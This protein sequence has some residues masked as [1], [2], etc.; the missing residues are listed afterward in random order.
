ML[1]TNVPM[2]NHPKMR[3]V[4]STSKSL[5]LLMPAGVLRQRGLPTLQSF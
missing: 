1:V 5:P 3:P 2:N 4:R